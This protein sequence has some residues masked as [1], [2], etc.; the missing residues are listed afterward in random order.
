MK[1]RTRNKIAQ[2]W[3]YNEVRYT[4]KQVLTATRGRVIWTRWRNGYDYY[5]G[6]D[7]RIYRRE[8]EENCPTCVHYNDCMKKY[9]KSYPIGNKYICA[10]YKYNLIKR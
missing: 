6:Y 3:H 1:Q 2:K 4:I 7:G 10:S 8:R 5:I 9:S